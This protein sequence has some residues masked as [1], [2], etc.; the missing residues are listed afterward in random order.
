MIE[1]VSYEV[2]PGESP[3][4]TVT[5]Y[6]ITVCELCERAYG[7]LQNRG[8]EFR[9]VVFDRL[10]YEQR[11]EIKRKVTGERKKGLLFPMIQRDGKDL[12]EGFNEQVWNEYLDSETE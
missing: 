7:Y 8:M 2:V 5:L 4:F 6:S 3:G 1:N 9:Y 10:P 12:L 11:R